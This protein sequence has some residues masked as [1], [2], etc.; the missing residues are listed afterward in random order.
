MDLF[1]IEIRKLSIL[2]L[3]FEPSL[4]SCKKYEIRSKAPYQFSEDLSSLS[5][6]KIKYNLI[7]RTSEQSTVR[8]WA[9]FGPTFF[10]S[11]SLWYPGS[12]EVNKN[13]FKT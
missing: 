1:P 5:R 3:G 7:S 13:I 10:M 8:L 4:K 6:L 2:S 9:I 12:N 11:I